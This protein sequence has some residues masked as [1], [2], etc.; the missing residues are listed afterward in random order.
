[1]NVCKSNA[2]CTLIYISLDIPRVQGFL[3]GL[4]M[5][6]SFIG[7]MCSNRLGGSQFDCSSSMEKIPLSQS[8]SWRPN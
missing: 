4:L 8:S 7:C 1:M 6:A 3:T 2:D 5:T